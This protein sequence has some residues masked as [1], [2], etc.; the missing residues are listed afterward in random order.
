[1]SV[2]MILEWI[3]SSETVVTAT[4]LVMFAFGLMFSLLRGGSK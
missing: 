2:L 1:M 4:L 3:V